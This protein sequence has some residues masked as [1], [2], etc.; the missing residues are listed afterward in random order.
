[1]CFM[2]LYSINQ[3]LTSIFIKLALCQNSLLLLLRQIYIPLRLCKENKLITHKQE[4]FHLFDNAHVFGT[5][6][7]HFHHEHTQQWITTIQLTVD[8]LME[9]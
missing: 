8:S 5:E 9:D 3:S 4:D 2:L 6:V 7:W 1:M